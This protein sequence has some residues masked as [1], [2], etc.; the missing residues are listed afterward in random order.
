MSHYKDSLIV[1]RTWKLG[2]SD[3]ILSCITR[4]N[5]KVRAVAKGA[6]KPKSKLGGRVEPFTELSALMW[7][8]RGE[9]DTVSQAEIIE[10]NAAIRE[11]FERL[12]KA[13]T[14]AEIVD[15]I[16]QEGQGL[17]TLFDLTSR[18]LRLL[19]E[20]DSPNFLAAFALR[21]LVVEGVSPSLAQCAICDS[22]EV[23]SLDYRAGSGLCAR[24][25][26][27]VLFGPGVVELMRLGLAGRTAVLLKETNPT[28]AF[29]LERVVFG[30][31]E[32]VFSLR[33]ASHANYDKLPGVM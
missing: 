14:V 22:E 23:V 19:S 20:R 17:E 18:A 10:S 1:L 29:E 33:L 27:Q 3:R 6:R 30:Y 21:L 16:G 8:G 28:A 5:G 11:D 9:L 24:H 31:M 7:R 15:K 26:S 4:S 2:E 25:S 12:R 32:T 13:S